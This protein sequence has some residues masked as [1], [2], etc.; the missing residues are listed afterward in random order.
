MLFTGADD[1]RRRPQFFLSP[2][3]PRLS[4][5][6]DLSSPFSLQPLRFD[7]DRS[8]AHSAC[9]QADAAV[10]CGRAYWSSIG[11]SGP[12]R[13]C[14]LQ[15]HNRL[16]CC[17]AEEAERESVSTPCKDVR[18]RPCQTLAVVFSSPRRVQLAL[19]VQSCC[20]CCC[21]VRAAAWCSA[22]A[23]HAQGRETAVLRRDLFLC[24][25]SSLL[26]LWPLA[27][28]SCASAA[29]PRVHA[30][31]RESQTRAKWIRMLRA[32][33]RRGS[34]PASHR[35]PSNATAERS[36]RAH[37]QERTGERT[38]QRQ[39]SSKLE[40]LERTHDPRCATLCLSTIA[41]QPHSLL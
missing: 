4:I 28:R 1:R 19:R 22:A 27:L 40:P 3:V 33:A 38:R 23:E 32:L 18:G 10:F 13:V 21:C 34:E 24:H 14:S 8:R 39:R 16:R 11:L 29:P 41:N 37:T 36:G 20:L 30:Q 31:H 6:A 35:A 26:G 25:C 7:V 17:R 5:S 2:C 15:P 9:S 12:P